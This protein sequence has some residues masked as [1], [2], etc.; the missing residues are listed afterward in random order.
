MT[1][2]EYNMSFTAGGL[3]NREAVTLA[4]RYLDLRDWDAVRKDV[5]SNNL[6][7]ARTEAS[8]TRMCREV[9]FRLRV[10]NDAEL[11]YFVSADPRERSYLLW[12]AACRR[13]GLLAEFS[14]EVVRERYISLQVD[15][16]HEDF[17]AFF[18]RKAEWHPELEGIRDST[19]DKL[20]QVTFRMLREAQLLDANN[21]IQPAML[22]AELIELIAKTDEQELFYFPAFESD[23][24]V[25][26]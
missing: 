6:L 16:N 2:S 1:Q 7:Q 19:R 17:D 21:L 22:S 8:L 14:S 5:V 11:T 24:K 12:L 25:C 18:N 10:L 23:I 15:L 3:F 9:G 26:A 4:E 13:H 20:R